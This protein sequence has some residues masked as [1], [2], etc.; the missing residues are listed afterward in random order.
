MTPRP[1]A[2]FIGTLRFSQKQALTKLAF[3]SVF[4]RLEAKRSNSCSLFPVF[5]VMLSVL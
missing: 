2:D 1:H 4:V 3:G 5:V